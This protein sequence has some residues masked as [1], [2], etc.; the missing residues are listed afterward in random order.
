MKKAATLLSMFALACSMNAQNMTTERLLEL[1]KVTGMGLTKDGKSVIYS[2]RTYSQT[3]G[4]A[5]VKKYSIPL[6][7]GTATEVQSTDGLIADPQHYSA[8]GK[9]SVTS[10]EIKI[11]NVFG[12]DFYPDQPKS[13]VMIYDNLNYRHWDTWEDGAFGH[14]FLNT[15]QNGKVVDSID[16]MPNE[17]YDC[18]QKP[19]GS[20]EDYILS[21]DGKQ[22][23]YVTKKK[24]GK[25]YAVSTN[26]D[27]YVYNIETKQTSNL[28]EGM[29]GYDINP[30]YSSTGTL[31]F[32]SMKEDGNEADKNDIIVV[33]GTVKTNLTAA[34][35]NTV[36]DFKWSADGKNIYFIAPV[37]GTLQLFVVDNP[38]LAKKIPV[39]K[40]ITK[41][42][43]D[44]HDIIGQSGNTMIVGRTDMN[45]ALEIYSADLTSGEMKQL[46]HVN[47]ASY[48]A[49]KLSKTERRWMTATDGQK[50]LVWVIYPPDFDA[51]KKYPTLLYCQG[52]PQSALTQFY[53][54]R[55]NFQL[56]AANGYIV[57]AP[58]RRGMPGHG[59][60]WNA[61]IS[62]DYGGQVMRDYL[63][64]IDE[65]AKEPFVDKARLGCVG[66]SFGGYSV[67]YL[68]GHHE[69]RFKTFIAHDGIFDWRSMYGTTEE[70][71]FTNH[72]MGGPFWNTDPSIQKSYNEFNPVNAVKK[73]DAPILIIHGG[74]DYRVPEE[75]GFA[76]FQA[77]QLLGLKSKLLYFPSENHWI[78]KDADSYV[79]QREFFK[80]LKETL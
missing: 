24:F 37:D 2:V 63:T 17:P 65:V 1:G 34:W 44:V 77:A 74:K 67:F 40:Q 14:V 53:S 35:D 46:T 71:F 38:G 64:A 45:H 62:K 18:P 51:S 13:D 80:W 15:L 50:M 55:W 20:E 72:D 3:E 61:E 76:A 9:H 19:H 57:V 75:Q 56:M 22:V 33:N 4:K 69:K 11:K 58:N 70:I 47:D 78:L 31:A 59:V 23:L 32:L 27:I 36:N 28:T 73:W 7:G 6:T 16:L 49:I 41:G 5:T 8:D 43:F 60:K 68:E 25:D 48:A 30:A 21:P 29:M 39:I 42:D 26:T 54:F 12:K 66:A 52:G 79:W 10:N